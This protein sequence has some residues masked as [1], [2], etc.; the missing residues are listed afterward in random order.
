MSKSIDTLLTESRQFAPSADYVAQA[1]VN[2]A[3]VYDQANADSQAWWVSWAEKLDWFKKWDTVLEWKQ[4]YAKWFLNGKINACYNC[5][6]R[7]VEQGRGDKV[8][9]IAEGE[10]GDIR[11][12]TYA[13]VQ[14]E[15]SKLANALKDQGVKKGDRVCIYLGHGPELCLS[16]L[17][18]ARIGAAHSVVFGGFSA[19][20]IAERINDAEA[21][22]V[23]TADGAWRRGNIV[24]LKKMVDDALAMGCPTIEKVLVHERVG[25]AG[26]ETIGLAV[27]DYDRGA[28][29][30]TGETFGG[31]RQPRAFQMIVHVS[32]WTAKTCCLSSTRADRRANRRG[33]CTRPAGT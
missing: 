25:S 18:C 32:R 11:R 10:P 13:D 19:S 24:P 27:P 33:S 26:T 22:M 8:A 3:G 2:D 1:N 28:L 31:T 15:V 30:R 29:G 17:A 6:D 20:S 14:R 7:H 21:K 4:P 5:V 12:F 16:M 9:W 23:I